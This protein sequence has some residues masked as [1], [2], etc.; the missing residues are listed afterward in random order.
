MILH[1]TRANIF[2]FENNIPENMKTDN[3]HN[4]IQCRLAGFSG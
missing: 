2:L 1:N 4:P 3:R